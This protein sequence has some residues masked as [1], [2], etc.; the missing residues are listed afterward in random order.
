MTRLTITEDPGEEF[1]VRGHNIVTEQDDNE[2]VF[3]DDVTKVQVLPERESFAI[4]VLT[5]DF[6]LEMD[7]TDADKVLEALGLFETKKVL[8]VDFDEP[9]SVR[10]LPTNP[11]ST[12]TGTGEIGSTPSPGSDF[13][14]DSAIKL[15]RLSGGLQDSPDGSV[16]APGPV[17][18]PITLVPAKT[19]PTWPSI[20]APPTPN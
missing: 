8:E 17:S 7:F 1:T 14:Q 5:P 15:F 11:E 18:P 4:Q 13:Q 20:W 12:L 19:L 9:G 6:V 3:Y 16:P 2:V 10:I